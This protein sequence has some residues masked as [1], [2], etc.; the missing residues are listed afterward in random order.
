M[1]QGQCLKSKTPLIHGSNRKLYDELLIMNEI[2][3]MVREI[4]NVAATLTV[5]SIF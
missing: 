3:S 5:K 1:K 2:K 4:H